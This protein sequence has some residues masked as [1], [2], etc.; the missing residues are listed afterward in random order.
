MS[1]TFTTDRSG[2]HALVSVSD[3]AHSAIALIEML[4]ALRWTAT[5]D[6]VVDLT[7]FATI[8]VRVAVVL[9]QARRRHDELGRSLTIACR[10][11]ADVRALQAV[12]LDRPGVLF[13]SLVDTG[14]VMDGS[15]P[16]SSEP[17]GYRPP[18]RMTPADRN[19]QRRATLIV[20][21]S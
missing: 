19:R 15:S 6:I 5:D 10:P 16:R 12:G 8:D 11:D 3:D 4:P 2:R 7:R 13:R 9:A 21:D 17:A 1:I 20:P 14:W 18:P